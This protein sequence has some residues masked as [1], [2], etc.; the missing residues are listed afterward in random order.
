MPVVLHQFQQS[1]RSQ[2]APAGR[3][4]DGGS[5]GVAKQETAIHHWKAIEPIASIRLVGSH[6]A[7][8]AVCAVPKMS[9][10]AEFDGFSKFTGCNG[11]YS[12]GSEKL[13]GLKAVA[14]YAR[15]TATIGQSI[16]PNC[17]PV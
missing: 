2:F 5:N 14:G 4:S 17:T 15:G 8:L 3:C 9:L 16:H 1:L 13:L 6:W 7:H 11:R 10:A 12:C